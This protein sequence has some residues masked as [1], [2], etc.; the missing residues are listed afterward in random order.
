MI[1]FEMRVYFNEEKNRKQESKSKTQTL[2][3]DGVIW[4]YE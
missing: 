2:R 3:G 1:F 4:F